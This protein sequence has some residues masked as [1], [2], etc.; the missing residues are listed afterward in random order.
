MPTKSQSKNNVFDDAGLTLIECLVAIVVIAITTAAIG[1]M[2]VFSVATRIQNQKTEQA[3]QLAQSE[4]DKVRLTVEQGGDYAARLKELSVVAHPANATSPDVAISEI[5][6][7][8]SNYADFIDGSTSP[9]S[10]VTQARMIDLDGDDDNDFAIQLFRT[11]GIA[12]PAQDS[13]LEDTPVTFDIGVR[14]YDARAVGSTLQ[15]E[16]A[17]LEFT[18]GEGERRTRPLAVI[19]GQIS[20]GDRDGSLC[21]YWELTNGSTPSSMLCN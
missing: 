1:P 12:V 16:P 9:A 7:P 18:S 19:Y 3:M 6:V 15:S 10:L 2:L 20:Q 14:V 4:I 17:G 13:S 11:R 5:P 8:G 21:Q